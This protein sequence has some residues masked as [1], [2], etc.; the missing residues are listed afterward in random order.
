MTHSGFLLMRN[1][2]CANK[3]LKN[4]FICKYLLFFNQMISF[5]INKICSSK[6]DFNN[7][8]IITNIGKNL[9]FNLTSNEKFTNVKRQ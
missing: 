3:P 7:D 1:F 4:G 6:F 2:K 8:F 5:I 9:N